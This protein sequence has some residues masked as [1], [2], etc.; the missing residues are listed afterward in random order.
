MSDKPVT[1]ERALPEIIQRDVV[2]QSRLF[3][4]E[5]L[6]LRF[7]NGEERVY[8]R[9]PGG[10]RHAVMIVPVLNNDTLLLIREYAA[11]T[12]AYELGFPKGLVDAGETDAE[13]ANRELQEEIGMATRQLSF[14]KQVSLAPGFMNARMAIFL[15]Q[16]LFPQQLTGDEP[17][18]LEII[19]WPLKDAEALL[20][21]PQFHE[22]RSVAALLLLLRQ[23]RDGRLI[24]TPA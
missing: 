4:V 19:A 18:P 16:D 14:L 9:I 24:P 5:S 21:H 11:G 17:E 1:S 12:H 6:H 13:A 15:A 3:R 23:L 10:N 20:E 22:A 2:A 8:E 7:S